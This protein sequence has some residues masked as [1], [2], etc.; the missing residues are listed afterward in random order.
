MGVFRVLVCV[1]CAFHT[2]TFEFLGAS[3]VECESVAFILVAP[4]RGPLSPV[5]PKEGSVEA[6]VPRQRK[7]E[8]GWDK[9]QF[10]N[11][12]RRGTGAGPELSSRLVC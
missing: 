1:S 2:K 3:A 12:V 4:L 11:C 7:R 6:F 5:A 9:T 8:V 10:K